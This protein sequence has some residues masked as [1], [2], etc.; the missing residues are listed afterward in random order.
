[1]SPKS[2]NALISL[3]YLNALET[4]SASSYSLICP[5]SSFK[6]SNSSTNSFARCWFPETMVTSSLFTVNALFDQ[7]AEP[8][9]TTL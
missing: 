9:I 4:S 8:L 2:T 5:E 7:L 1:M 3:K 6:R